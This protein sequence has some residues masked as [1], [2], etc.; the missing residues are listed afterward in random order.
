[1]DWE[2][3]VMSRD[4]LGKKAGESPKTRLRASNW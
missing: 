3:G 1:V 2:G 4:S